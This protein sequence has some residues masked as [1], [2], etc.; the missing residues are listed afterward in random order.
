MKSLI[1]MLIA[2]WGWFSIVDIRM[3]ETQKQAD[4]YLAAK[5]PVE[6]EALYRQIMT[7]EPWRNL[8]W[9][10]VATQYLTRHETD[11]AIQLLA[12]MAEEGRLSTDGRLVL[13]EAYKQ[14]GQADKVGSTLQKA[15][16]DAKDTNDVVSVLLAQ[17]DFYRSHGE[18]RSALTCQRE[19][20]E[21]L[22]SE[23]DRKMDAI[24][25]QALFDQKA[26]E[27]EWQSMQ[28]KPAWFEQWGSALK[29]VLNKTD[30]SGRWLLLGQAYG[31]AGVWDLAEYSFGQVVRLAPM[32]SQA[33]ALLAE[34]RQQQGKD[35]SRQITKALEIDPRSPSVR[36]AAALFYRRQSDFNRAIEM[37][38]ANITENPGEPLW[39]LE[40]GRTLAEAGS[41][42][43]ALAAYQ[44]AARKDPKGIDNRLAIVRFCVQYNYRV[45]DIGLPTARQAVKL[46][47]ESVDVLDSLGQVYFSLGNYP[48]ARDIFER[49]LDKDEAFAPAWLHM[50]QLELAEGESLKAKEALEKVIL[51]AGNSTESRLA[52]RLLQQYFPGF[53]TQNSGE[54]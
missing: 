26:A 29:T 41:F 28:G 52:A 33:W 48:E 47:P 21:M 36:L 27:V 39:Y 23:P 11:K 51:L 10:S 3:A 12:P 44:E 31:A 6:A 53:A 42:E 18:F 40:M 45:K 14:N 30:D 9:N 37:L 35:G 49:V 15:R 46:S 25:L 2:L 20:S 19:L 1:V 4:Q 34:S 32:N 50:A 8:N 22:D 13:A 38:G 16:S 24:L 54:R 5:F 7:V 17:V 43:D